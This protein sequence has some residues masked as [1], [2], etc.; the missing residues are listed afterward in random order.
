MWAIVSAQ[1]LEKT[2]GGV[3]TLLQPCGPGDWTRVLR[4]GI[5]EV[6]LLIEP[7]QGPR[8]YFC[9]CY[10]C[11]WDSTSYSSGWSQTSDPPPSTP[12]ILGLQTCSITSCLCVVRYQSK[13]LQRHASTS[14]IYSP[15][16]M[17][18]RMLYFWNITNLLPNAFSLSPYTM[19]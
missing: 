14:E 6:P 2:L 3:G 18:I 17:H 4:L 11:F 16:I 15:C 9:S 7:S 19:N 8:I 1:K 5:K 13:S 12:Q 10:F